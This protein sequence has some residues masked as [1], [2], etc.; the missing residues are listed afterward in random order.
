MTRLQSVIYGLGQFKEVPGPILTKIMNG[1]CLRRYILL[2]REKVPI[3]STL[4]TGFK[5]VSVDSTLI[6]AR[7]GVLGRVTTTG[8]RFTVNLFT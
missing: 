4:I 2:Q 1:L 3:L 8:H 5:R 6:L 7:F